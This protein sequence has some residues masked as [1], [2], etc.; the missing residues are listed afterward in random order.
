MRQLARKYAKEYALLDTLGSAQDNAEIMGKL[1]K[2]IHQ[3]ADAMEKETGVE[4]SMVMLTKLE[5]Y[6]D[7]IIRRLEEKTMTEQSA[8][9]FKLVANAWHKEVFDHIP[10]EGGEDQEWTT[11]DNSSDQ[12][13][14]DIRG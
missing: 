4:S 3:H 1:V 7:L 6:M 8:P 9:S 2:L 11:R 12:W 10:K 5:Q 14:Q 13:I